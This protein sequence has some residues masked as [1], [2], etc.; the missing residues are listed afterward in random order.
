MAVPSSTNLE[1]V[2]RL[3]NALL[4]LSSNVFVTISDMD[5]L[6]GIKSFTKLL[7]DFC[8]SS[9][10]PPLPFFFFFNFVED[11]GQEED[12]L[13][14]VLPIES[15]RVRSRTLVPVDMERCNK[16]FRSC[17]VSSCCSCCAICKS[18]A[19]I[20]LNNSFFFLF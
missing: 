15:L 8:S 18:I 4:L 2:A 12:E 19:S 9:P 3:A 7:S 10:S 11:A 13:L 1:R 5:I 14:S 6:V 20:E 17:A 16:S